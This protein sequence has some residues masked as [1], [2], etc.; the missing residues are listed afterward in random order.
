MKKYMSEHAR[1]A[2]MIRQELKKNG[3]KARVNASS[4]AGGSSIRVVLS[5]EIPAVVDAVKS[6]VGDYQ[7]GHFNGMEDIYEYS[8][9]N[10]S[11]PQVKFV[12]V[13]N[14]LSDDIRQAAWD[15]V[16]A[17]WG[18]MEAAPESYEDARQYNCKNGNGYDLIAK[19]LYPY[20]PDRGGFWMAYKM[21][22]AA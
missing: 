11:L 5:N 21:R 7:M 17:N 4:Y 2:K 22:I 10:K 18:D 13:E 9:N 12:F 14:S 8:N 16:K 19:E 1:A 6:Y 15:Y 20:G 3:I